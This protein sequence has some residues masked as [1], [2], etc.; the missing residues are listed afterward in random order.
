M[1]KFWCPVCDQG[2][3][4]PATVKQDATFIWVCQECEVL[5]RGANPPEREPDDTF[6]TYMESRGFCPLWTE[7]QVLM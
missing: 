5:W 4:V 2:W 3:V 6:S 1:E 7:I